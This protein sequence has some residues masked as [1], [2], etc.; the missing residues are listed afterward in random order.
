MPRDGQLLEREF[1][2]F[3]FREVTRVNKQQLIEPRADDVVFIERLLSAVAVV[4]EDPLPIGHSFHRLFRLIVLPDDRHR[5]HPQ[6]EGPP[7]LVDVSFR[8]GRS[9]AEHRHLRTLRLGRAGNCF[10]I[11]VRVGVF[12]DGD[13]HAGAHRVH[14]MVHLLRSEHRR[15]DHQQHVVDVFDRLRWVDRPIVNVVLFAQ[16]CDE[17]PLLLAIA[18]RM[19]EL[20]TRVQDAHL[21]SLALEHRGYRAHQFVFHGDAFVEK[22]HD[23]FAQTG[24][25][26][27]G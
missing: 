18:R 15:L 10:R 25:D 11:K 20:N 3:V 22:R 2:V 23:H 16:F 8:L 13:R 4:D 5:V 6:T 21:Q 9:S 17:G 7:E 27:R 14:Q 24:G 19:Q 1:R 12:Q 26:R